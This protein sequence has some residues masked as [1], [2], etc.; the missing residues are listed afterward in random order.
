MSKPKLCK[1]CDREI[2]SRGLCHRHYTRWKEGKR[3]AELDK[4]I[5]NYG[6]G[7]IDLASD[8]GSPSSTLV[9]DTEWKKFCDWLGIREQRKAPVP[10]RTAQS[11]VVHGV[12]SDL[13]IPFHDMD[14]IIESIQWLLEQKIDVLWL[15]GDVADHYSLSRFSQYQP[16]SIQQEAIECRKILDLLCR[17]FPQVNI[18]SGNHE[19]R[20]NKYLA[21]RLPADLL[22]WFLAKSFMERITEDMP[23]VEIQKRVVQ[24]TPMHWITPVGDDAVIAHAESASKI[25]LRAAENVRQWMDN[26]HDVLDLSRPRFIMQAHTHQ[27]GSAPVGNQIVCE[28]GC[29]C[30]VQGY[31]LEPRLYGKPQ[32]QAATAFTQINGRTDINSIRQ[33]YL[34]L[35]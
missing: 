1:F 31:A 13:H 29:V 17:S 34:Q 30:K 15:G 14:A 32:R 22:Q 18:I 16:I 3:G 2:V 4:P 19:S 8:E 27:C 5:R 26:W 11:S 28:L 6:F 20:E 24:G 9:Y 21:S 23:N 25:S 12:I 10:K 7:E 33:R 35:H